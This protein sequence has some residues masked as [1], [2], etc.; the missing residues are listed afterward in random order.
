M[1]LNLE[2]LSYEA[3]TAFLARMAHT[4]TICARGTYEIGTDNVLN[5][6]ILRAYNELLHQVT[7]SILSR[8]EQSGR[9][10]LGLKIFTSKV[11]RLIP[12]FQ[13]RHKPSCKIDPRNHLVLQCLFGR[14]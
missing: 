8:T 6:Q 7:G 4:L 5:P 2:S 3:K 10:E 1:P 14:V 9:N 11:Q 13:S 12:F